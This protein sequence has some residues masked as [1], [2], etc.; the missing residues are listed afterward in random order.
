MSA[1]VELR[2]G[3]RVLAVTTGTPLL[4]VCE[5]EDLPLCFSCRDGACGTCLV[6]VVEGGENLSPRSEN[7]DIVLP[8]LSDD[9]RA[10]LACQVRVLGP[11]RIEAA[12]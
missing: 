6:H 1:A 7:E 3:D 9:P 4:E 11:V 8:E 10:R 12:D 5:N 2:I